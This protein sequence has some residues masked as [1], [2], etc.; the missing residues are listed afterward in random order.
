VP[1]IILQ[2]INFKQM[3][4]KFDLSSVT[5]VLTGAAPLGAETYVALSE[6]YPS[7]HLSQ[8]YGLTETTSA[9][10]LTS[11]RYPF[12]GSPG[13]EARLISLRDGSDITKC[14]EAGELLVRS[15]SVTSLGYLHDD[16]ATQETFR[17]LDGGW[18][19]T[20][21]EAM[22]VR[23]TNSADGEEHLFIIDR[24]KELI[25]VNVRISVCLTGAHPLLLNKSS[26]LSY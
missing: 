16:K 10:S 9:V 5:Q 7:W 23:N 6:L 20:G 24:I 12:P 8:G 19:R 3:L 25:K 1:P 22:F 26:P 14:G 2:M 11:T 15:P 18:M 4:N 21:D 13:Q 17:A